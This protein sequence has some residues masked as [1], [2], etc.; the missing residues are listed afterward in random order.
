QSVYD[1]TVGFKKT[2]AEPTLISILK[3]RTCQAEM[4][5][6][7]FPISE[8]PTD[9]EGSS[10]W[11]HELYREKDKIYDYFVQH[12]TFEGNGLPRIEIPRNYYDLLIQLGWTIIIGIPSIIYFFQF[13][14]TSSLLAQIIFVI[15][16]CIATI[17]VRTMIA[18]TETERGSH[19][20]EI[21]KED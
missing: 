6:R 17:G 3:G 15:I 18:I 5:I 1:I 20:G 2:G 16:I 9:T 8:I 10:N 11:I 4:F 14:W 13:L 7:R 19:Y 12:N 21:N